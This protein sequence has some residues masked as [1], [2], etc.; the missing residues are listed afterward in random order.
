MPGK[1][2]RQPV[3]DEEI[4]KKCPTC[5]QG[6]WFHGVHVCKRRTC[7]YLTSRASIY[8]KDK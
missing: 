1:P 6:Y 8:F 7:K 5:T 3:T 4:A 2:R